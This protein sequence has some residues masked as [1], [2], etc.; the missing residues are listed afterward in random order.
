MC[1]NDQDVKRL[2]GDDTLTTVTIIDNDNPGTV[3]FKERNVIC[4]PQDQKLTLEVERQDGSS[5]DVS[6][7]FEITTNSDALGGRP[8]TKGIDWIDPIAP[9]DKLV[10]KNGET[11]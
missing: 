8:A 4:R 3:G 11:E 10:F 1:D 6:V 5:G 2:E 7:R 9:K